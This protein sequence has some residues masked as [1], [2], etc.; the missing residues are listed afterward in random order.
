MMLRPPAVA[1]TFYPSDRI[2]LARTVDAFLASAPAR[3][4]PHPQ[5]IVVPHAGYIY[6]GPVAAAAYATIAADIHRVVL[7]GPAH[8]V[9]VDGLA[10][11]TVDAFATPLGNVPIDAA[12][13]TQAAALPGVVLDDRPHAT[14]HSLEV[15][16]PFLQRTLGD[17]TLLPFAVGRASTETVAAVIDAVWG[18]A[19]TL[20]VVSTD[21][22]HY[23]SYEDASIHDRQTAAAIIGRRSAMIGTADACGAIPLRGLLAAT[24]IQSLAPTLL[25]LRSSG[26]TNGPRDRVVGYGAFTFGEPAHV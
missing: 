13:R 20:V 1:G 18:G 14:E 12:L 8:R 3:T 25:D 4:G 6:S 22:S 19:E 9:A 16:L 7:F 2:E 21:L 10:L 24:R 17:F 5:A 26:D 11:P 23:E 15:Q